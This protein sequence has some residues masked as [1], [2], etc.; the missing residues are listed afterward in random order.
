MAATDTLSDLRSVLRGAVTTPG[1][2]GWDDARQAWNLAVDQH[3]ALVVEAADADD[4]SATVRF[5]RETGLRVAVQ[6]TGHGAAPRGGDLADAIL[7]RTSSMREVTVDAASR[8]AR[9]QAGAQWG[10][11][12]RATTPH[13]LVALHGS[14]H[15]VGVVG[16][17]L[18]GGIGWLARKHGLAATHVTGFDVV[19][20]DGTQVR[21]TATECPQLF[22]ALRGGGGSYAIVTAIEFSLFTLT[23]IHAGALMWPAERAG[24]VL[25]AW[26]DLT[27]GL[28][29]EITSLGRLLTFP[30]FPE[31]PEGLRGRSMVIVEAA[32]LLDADATG[33][34]LAPLR[35]LG[36]EVDTFATGPVEMLLE[37]HGDPPHPVPGMGGGTMLAELPDAAIDEAVART[38]PGSPLLSLEFRHLGGALGRVPAGAGA[39]GSLQGRFAVYMVGMVTGPEAAA[40]IEQHIG[41]TR[42]GL[43]AWSTGGAYL[44]FTEEPVDAGQAFGTTTV[45]R[46][47][48]IAAAIDPER[49]LV[50]NHQVQ[51]Y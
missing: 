27:D 9:A 30:P 8:T 20:P 5:A 38:G 22:W 49:L 12:V 14:S 45:R 35:D 33:A 10:D 26:R 7:L 47:R 18:G 11:V 37:L 21:V 4:V 29:D 6:G 44:N 24:E 2:A 15:D 23:E 43:A 36:P 41:V 39:L 16:Y 31:I 17:T 3:P 32:S 46:L 48:D 34:L 25:R 42:D 13:G 51:A 40:A 50:A 28:P 1:D 19:V